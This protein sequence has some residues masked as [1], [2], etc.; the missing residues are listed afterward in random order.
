[1]PL[2]I[3]QIDI[4]SIYSPPDGKVFYCGLWNGKILIYDFE[5]KTS[6]EVYIGF[7]ESPI[8]TFENLGNNKLVVGS[9]GEGALILDTENITASINN[10]NY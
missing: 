2:E 7:E 6:K 4:A 10:P 3:D 8:V 1:M 5:K 9:F